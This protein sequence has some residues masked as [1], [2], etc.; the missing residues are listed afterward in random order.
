M[1]DRARAM[2]RSSRPSSG[3][4]SGPHRK[5]SWPIIPVLATSTCVAFTSMIR[6]SM[7]ICEPPRPESDESRQGRPQ[8]GQAAEPAFLLGPRV[9]DHQGVDSDADLRQIVFA[10]DLH[11]VELDDVMPGAG[12][13][14]FAQAMGP[15]LA[16]SF[17]LDRDAEL[18]GQD[19]CGPQR[20][21]D[22][23]GRRADEGIGDDRDRPV[24]PRRDDRIAA[25]IE[26]QPD[27]RPAYRPLR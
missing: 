22:E 9:A 19:I 6:S 14:P 16:R 3:R 5:G 8:V 18:P 25:S 27:D 13:A 4:M 1:S 10:I 17:Q 20:E 26:R 7:V 11:G 15:E 23:V 2:Q 24:A 21:D 12:Q